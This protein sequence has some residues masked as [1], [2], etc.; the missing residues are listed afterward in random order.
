M[1]T[2]RASSPSSASEFR[3]SPSGSSCGAVKIARRVLGVLLVLIAVGAAGGYVYLRSSLPQTGG[4]IVVKGPSAAIRILRDKDGVATI[5]ARNDADAAFGLGFAHAQE[6]LFQMEL[7]RRLGAG[8]L[9]EIFG[10]RAVPI[11]RQMRI[12]GL[13]RA[14]EAEIRFLSPKVRRVLA[15]YAAGVNAYLATHQGALSPDFLLL[16]FAPEEWRVADSLV[17]GKLMALRLEGDYRGELLRARL[18]EAIPP[19]D[20]KILYPRYPKDAP[21]TLAA[22]RPVYRA[23]APGRLYAMLA[24]PVGPIFESNNWVVDGRHSA[25]GKPV[26]ANDPH[27]GFAAPGVWFLARLETPEHVITGATAPGVPFVIIGHNR[28][29]AWGVTDTTSDVEDLFIEKTDPADPQRYLTPR[30]S[31]PFVVHHEVIRVRGEKPVALVVRSTRHGSVVSDALPRGAARPGSVLA[32]AATFTR[33]DDRTA[34]ALYDIDR[35]QNWRQF[36]AGLENFLGPQQNFVFADS[37]GTIGFIAPGLVPIRRNGEG[38]LPRP[39]WTGKYDWTGF[40]PFAQLPQATNPPSGHFISANNK[41]VPD[42]YPYYLGRGWDLPNR[43]ERIADLLEAHPRQ[44][45]ASSA[46]IEADTYSIIAEHLVPLM[47]DIR[48]NDKPA[49]AALALLARWDFYMDR[50]KVAPLIF[51]AWLREFSREILFA[52]F[53]RAIAPYWNLHPRVMETILTRHRDW[54]DDPRTPQVESCAARLTHSLDVALSALRRAY[55]GDMAQWRWARAHVAQF[56]NPVLSRIPILRDLFA[57]TIP[58]GGGYDTIDRGVSALRDDGDPFVE[59]FGAGLRI[60]TDLAAPQDSRMIV[61][62][63]QSGNPLSRHYADLLRRWRDFGWLVPGRAR[64][65]A[66]LELVPAR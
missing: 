9:A 65:A 25:S 12:L 4:R 20:L 57:V 32:L 40:I 22:L 15:A 58:T 36:R 2:G 50:G 66:S 11:D 56:R 21:T 14:A 34:E 28:H 43:A 1:P 60:I 44:T 8:R 51:T 62:P 52:R 38:W 39:G 18:A 64:A 53:G 42:S 61:T 33:A 23:L 27:L 55:G 7:M 45:A 35:A 10:P 29:I 3:L 30:G 13:Y 63:G 37:S 54:C 19:A 5:I 59:R 41:I 48:P 47:T 46:A 31:A 24:P 6:R 16:R 26:L 49:R 17:W